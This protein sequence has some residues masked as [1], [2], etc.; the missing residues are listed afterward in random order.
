MSRRL[1]DVE[2][3]NEDRESTAAA[4]ETGC[5][6]SRQAD[7]SRELRAFRAFDRR[8]YDCNRSRE[9]GMAIATLVAHVLAI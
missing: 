6:S 1:C 4:E 2:D 9:D 3:M 8:A 7:V 5:C